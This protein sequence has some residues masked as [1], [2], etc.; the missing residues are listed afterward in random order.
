MVLPAFWLVFFGLIVIATKGNLRDF[1]FDEPLG[2]F[3]AF[4]SALIWATFWIFNLKDNRDVLIKL[5]M[6]FAFGFFYISLLMFFAG[7]DVFAVSFN[8]VLAAVYVGLFEMGVTFVLWLNALK[9]SEDTA[10]VSSLIY[11][12]PFISLNFISIILGEKILFSTIIGV[13]LIVGGILIQKFL[14]SS[15]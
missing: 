10:K 5:S 14:S 6:S 2:I 11:L 7:I 1:N 3:L 9:N 12:A 8:S 15:D 13:V 4:G